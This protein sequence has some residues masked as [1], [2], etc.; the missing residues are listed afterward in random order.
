MSFEILEVIVRDI[1]S[2]HSLAIKAS[3]D[4]CERIVKKRNLSGSSV[5]ESNEI[6]SIRRNT[7][8]SLTLITFLI[9]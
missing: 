7:V 2:F 3:R 9:R 1:P 4:F 5:V 8:L 6:S